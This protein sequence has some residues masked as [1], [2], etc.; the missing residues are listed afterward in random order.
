MTA[1]HLCGINTAVFTYD[2]GAV[3]KSFVTLSDEPMLSKIANAAATGISMW[4]SAQSA[5]GTK[6]T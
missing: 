3:R 2:A 5:G 1:I 4:R 6:T